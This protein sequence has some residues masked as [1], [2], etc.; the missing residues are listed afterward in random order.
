MLIRSGYMLAFYYFGKNPL[1]ACSFTFAMKRRNFVK[2]SLLTGS[3]AGL[4]PLESTARRN[5]SPLQS[6]TREFYELRVYSLK[7][8]KQR[9]LVEDYFQQA[10]I[11]ALNKLG[12]KNIGVFTEY[13]SQGYTKLVILIP[14]S[15]MEDFTT[16]PEKMANDATYQQAATAYL[17]APASEPAYER[18]ES[19][20]L[21]AFSGMPTL[22]IPEKKQRLF[23]LRRYESPSESAGKKKIEMFNQ[24]GEITIFKRTGLTPVF[25]GE[26]IIGPHRPNLTYMLAFDDMAEH[27]QNW[28]RFGSDPDW[29]KIS[30]LPEYADEKILSN[31]NRTF[32]VPTSFS[33]I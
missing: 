22:E 29:K 17:T 18:I 14:Y 10:A 24:A 27:D 28:K 23:E 15:S 25:F 33:Q 3:A 7:N 4:I 1:R 30:S 31:I 19:S 6:P 32:L 13:L 2:T 20:F 5:H 11:P 8:A 12:S 16:A 9:N 21:Q 26:T